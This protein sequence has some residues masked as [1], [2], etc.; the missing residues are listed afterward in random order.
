MP[1]IPVNNPN[2]VNNYRN[3]AVWNHTSGALTF[4]NSTG[5]EYVHIAHKSGS[6]LTFANQA[7]S[8]FNPNNRQTLTNG[9]TFH[10]TKGHH[11]VMAQEA[12]HRVFGDFTVITGDNNLYTTPLLEGYMKEQNKLAAAKSSPELL[13]PGYGNVT[14]AVHTSSGDSPDA[15]TGSTQGK[16]FKPNPTH[17]N[18]AEVYKDTQQKLTPYERQMGD[19]GHIKLLSGKDILIQA[20]TAAT[21]FDTV[22]INPVGREVTDR[23][24]FDG[25]KTITTKKTSAPYFEEKDVASNIPFGNLHIQA[26]NK[27][28]FNSAA[29]GITFGT[30]GPIRMN[31][32]GITTIGGAQVNITGGTGGGASG[33]VFITSGDL[34]ELEAGNINL[35]G[36]DDIVI[37]PG[38]SVIGNQIISG[39]LVIGGNLKVLGNITCNGTLLV[40]KLVTAASDVH[41]KTNLEITG[42]THCVKNI[43]CDADV[44]ASGISLVKHVHMEQGDGKKVS[45]PLM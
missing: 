36:N 11:S 43:T 32:L 30:S 20:G 33:H 9:D 1:D 27:L 5:R 37:E 34:L 2:E 12:E 21:N 44:I 16:N 7:T 18:I 8:E 4:N 25:D 29:G 6:H 10:T 24:D 38:L 17:T 42:K 14:G 26:S 28:D 35:K 19:G 45:K 31:G 40:E 22:F 23:L 39:D 13:Q 41:V 15:K 3:K